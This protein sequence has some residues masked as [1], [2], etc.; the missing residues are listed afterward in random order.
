MVDYSSYLN[1]PLQ[2]HVYDIA[3]TGNAAKDTANIQAAINAAQAGDTVRFGAGTFDVSHITLKSSVLYEGQAGAVLHGQGG[4]TPMVSINPADSHD[5]KI[6]HLTFDNGQLSMLGTNTAGS[7]DHIT[8]TNSTFQNISASPTNGTGHVPSA[9]AVF[10]T[11]LKNSELVNN[12]FQNVH[13]YAGLAG[14]HLQ[15]TDIAYNTFKNVYEGMLLIEEGKP[16]TGQNIDVNHNVID[17]I[18]RAGIEIWDGQASAN[19]GQAQPAVMGTTQNLHVENNW[20]GNWQPAAVDST[21]NIMAYSVVTNGGI[22]TVVA[23]NYAAAGTAE[24]GNIGIELAG[25]GAQA[26]DNYISGFKTG[27]VSYQ[28]NQII[29]NNNFTG[30]TYGTGNTAVHVDT[31]QSS[32]DTISGNV[33]DTSMAAPAKP[34]LGTSAAPAP[35]PTPAPTPSPTPTPSTAPD[36]IVL[37]VSEDA[38][39]GNA[40][41]KLLADGHLIGE[42]DVTASHK[43]GAWQDIAFSTQLAHTTQA[44]TVQFTNDAY[45]GAGADRNLYVASATIDGHTLT[46]DHTALYSSHDV[47]TFDI[48]HHSEVFAA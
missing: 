6:D 35:S 40:H 19:Q 48:A 47:A 37:H 41:F 16:N 42:S 30:T 14:Y 12:T 46:P 7:A 13:G 4:T 21:N 45:G 9:D 44:L 11:Y 28:P 33:S 39:N 18:N 34:S 36:K 24:K 25:P 23:N 20:F 27:L 26:H 10:F 31:A 22:G 5:I 8:I 3:P 43:A 38:W 15:D 32:G 2:G 1:I 29:T 17:G